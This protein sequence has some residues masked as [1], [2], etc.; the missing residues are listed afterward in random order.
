MANVDA[1]IVAT[2]GLGSGILGAVGPGKRM[3]QIRTGM[4]SGGVGWRWMEWGVG[5]WVM[6][7]K[8]FGKGSACLY[9]IA[10]TRCG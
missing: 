8:S 9:S 4:A 10:Q 2:V 7:E 6:K 3:G 1:Q 5:L